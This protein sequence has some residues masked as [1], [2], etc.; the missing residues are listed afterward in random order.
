MCHFPRTCPPANNKPADS[1]C[2]DGKP[3]GHTSLS[4]PEHT[5][6]HVSSSPKRSR[7]LPQPKMDGAKA[8]ALAKLKSEEEVEM[9][10]HGNSSQGQGRRALPTP[11][12]PTSEGRDPSN[13]S[14][15]PR[16][17]KLTPIQHSGSSVM[18]SVERNSYAGPLPSIPSKD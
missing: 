3:D 12:N 1:A 17:S 2:P 7:N 9:A 11:N 10:G 8:V 6:V 4:A 14:V 18:T 16:Q 13:P 15:T 5:A